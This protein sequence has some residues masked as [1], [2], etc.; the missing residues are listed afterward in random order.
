MHHWRADK[1]QLMLAEGNGVA[2]FDGI[3]AVGDVVAELFEE[4]FG[5]RGAQHASVGVAHQNFVE[6]CG[7]VGFS[8]VNDDEVEIAAVEG[9][10]DVFEELTSAGPV[11][12]VEEH[13]L[14]IF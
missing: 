2:V 4:G 12:G 14:F 9:R 11:Y 13:R 5:L 1:G 3:D 6:G 8:V 7:V 10:F